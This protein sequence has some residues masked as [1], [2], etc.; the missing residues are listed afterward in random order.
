MCAFGC[1]ASATAF[2][3]VCLRVIPLC[4]YTV[5]TDCY[6]THQSGTRRHDSDDTWQTCPG[7][8]GTVDC[9]LAY[10]QLTCLF[11]PTCS[12]L[13]THMRVSCAA[14]LLLLLLVFASW[15]QANLI[16]APNLV[17]FWYQRELMLQWHQIRWWP[18]WENVCPVCLCHLRGGRLHLD[19]SLAG[20]RCRKM[21]G[22]ICKGRLLL[23]FQINLDSWLF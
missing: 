17:S 9:S 22:N 23:I 6:V 8:H 14:S 10:M 3:S 16:T 4:L 21:R 7:I 19:S 12:I 18:W 5:H 2:L 20:R 15:L 11:P 1:T 13:I